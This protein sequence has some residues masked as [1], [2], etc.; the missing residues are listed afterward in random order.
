MESCA[1]KLR[2]ESEFARVAAAYSRAAEA[3]RAAIRGDATKALEE[4]LQAR[5]ACRA[6]RRALQSHVISHRC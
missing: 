3:L 4:I 1:E 5:K 2:L 6:A